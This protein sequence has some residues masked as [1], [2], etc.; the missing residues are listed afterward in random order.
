MMMGKRRKGTLVVD[1]K[2]ESKE[3]SKE[4][5]G[6]GGGCVMVATMLY[7]RDNGKGKRDER[8]EVEKVW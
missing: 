3:H 4:A 5:E 7:V 8:K 2:T 1:F 6:F